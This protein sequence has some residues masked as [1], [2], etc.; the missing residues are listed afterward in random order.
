MWS[1]VNSP[2]CL[3][4]N[5]YKIWDASLQQAIISHTVKTVSSPKKVLSSYRRSEKNTWHCSLRCKGKAVNGLNA[6][7]S[8]TDKSRRIAW[9][10]SPHTAGSVPTETSHHHCP[11]N[12]TRPYCCCWVLCIWSQACSTPSATFPSLSPRP[13]T[14]FSGRSARPHRPQRWWGPLGFQTGWS[15]SST[16]SLWGTCSWHVC[17][18]TGGRAAA[19]PAPLSGDPE[20]PGGRSGTGRTPRAPRAHWPAWSPWTC[21]GRGTKHSE[22][23]SWWVHRLSHLMKTLVCKISGVT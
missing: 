7:W 19:P 13:Q 3:D 10:K 23:M 6:D 16:W 20:P 18:S 4:A 8:H 12:I 1:T 21:A 11:V 9:C 14:R 15:W 17:C 5:V 22:P 2:Q